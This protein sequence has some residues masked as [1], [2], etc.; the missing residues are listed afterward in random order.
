MRFA[1]R[2]WVDLNLAAGLLVA[3]L[4]EVF[5]TPKQII[6]PRALAQVGRKYEEFTAH[7]S[8][9]NVLAAIVVPNFVRAPQTAARNQTKVNQALVVLW[10]GAIS[11]R[12]RWLP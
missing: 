8:P 2:G 4:I 10:T 6:E 1:P 12:A 11:P 7:W 9:K 5:D 3:T